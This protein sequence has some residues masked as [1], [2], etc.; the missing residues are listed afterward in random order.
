MLSSYALVCCL[1]LAADPAVEADVVI[2]GVEL[3]DGSGAAGVVGDVAIRGERIVAVGRFTVAGKPRLIDGKGLV[4]AP[5]FIDLH[6]HSDNPLAASGHARQ[7]V[8]CIQGVTTVVTG[9][10]GSGPVDVAKYFQDAGERQSRHQR[11]PSGAAQR[12]APASHEE[13][14]PDADGR[15]TA[16]D[17][18]AG[19]ESA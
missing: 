2:R 4:V 3:Y 11:H 14:Q 9:N 13:R 19:R 6:T 17:G 1:V 8:I 16:A 15:R 18:S 5:G 10:C 12:R 7:D